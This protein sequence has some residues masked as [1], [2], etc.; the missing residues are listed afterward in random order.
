MRRAAINPL[1][2]RLEE[3][4]EPKMMKKHLLF[5]FLFVSVS[6]AAFAQT[7]STGQITGV[8]K[9]P[10]QAVVADTQVIL[11][12]VLTKVK[13][14]AITDAQGIYQ[15]S[16]LQP[17]AYVVEIDA[18]GFKPGRSSELNVTAGQTV[19]LDFALTLAGNVE[20]VYVSAG[21]VEN[22]YRVDNVK[23]GS[24]FGTV[25][26][27]NL[28]YSVNV[29]SRQLIDDTQSR[30]FKEVA[31]YLP[32]I[33]FREQQGP[34]ILRPESRGMQGTNMQNDRKD[35]M[36]FA[37]TTPSALEEYEQIEV[38]NGLGGPM[39]GPTQP[40]GVFNFVT[41]RPTDEQ[42]REVELD[43]EGE[44]VGTVHAD[45]GGRV[46]PNHMFGYRTNLVLADGTGYVDDS[47]L[48]RQLAAVALDVRITP[49]TVVEGNFSYYEL[50]QH[51]YPGWFTYA[52]TTTPLSVA[53]SKSILLPVNAPDP[54]RRGYGQSFS[55]VDMNNQIGE[56]RVKHELNRNWHLVVGVL[57]QIADRDINTAVN[58]LTDNKGDYQ[59]YLAD[60]FQNTLAPRFQVKSDLAYLTGTFKTWKI[61]HEVV[62]GS[63]GY[64]FASWQPSVPS[65]LTGTP[66]RLT[67]LCPAGSPVVKGLP[68]CAPSIATP[69]IAVLPANGIPSLTAIYIASIIHQQGFNFS[70][71]IT[72]TP[73]WLVRVGASQ[74]WIWEN[75]YSA[76]AV[77]SPGDFTSQGVS[78]TGS[79]IFKPRTN[80]TVYGTYAMSLQAPDTPAVSNATNIVINAAKALAPYHDKEGEIGYKLVLRKINFSTALFRIERPFENT[81]PAPAGACGT[82]KP[83]QTCTI[84]EIIGTQVNYGAEAVLSGRIIESLMVTGGITVLNPKLTGTPNPATDDKSL[85]GIPDYKSNILA[86]YRL[87]LLTG[88]FL[89]FDWEHVGR[90]P[91][92]DINSSYTPQYNLFDLGVRY[93]AKVFGKI[94][95]WRVTANNVSD[96]HY[97]STIN[98][99]SLIGTSAGSYLG[100]LGEPRLITASMRYDF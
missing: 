11:T 20:T 70:D 96:V 49:K 7:A 25:P 24:P 72:L 78:P 42:Y 56:V 52:P 76:A 35:G 36:G 44:S 68:V 99:G 5:I 61:G 29:I 22:A 63:T 81:A 23:P 58:K 30:N 40:S 26:I 97:W 19:N 98:P 53:G 27:V 1:K 6:L 37:V 80:M 39:Y 14:T 2:L 54:T 92:D 48:R 32:L 10:H 50:F 66:F 91:I 90:R 89:N 100:H 93:T 75:F 73:H 33:S 51:G 47:Q 65:V 83:G 46:G 8:V 55:G 57:N 64:R 16:A 79:I 95:T 3:R 67:P 62:I 94:A 43:Y 82:L 41:K 9:D 31:K 71:T 4:N 60:A 86:E 84:N 28:P 38:L 74:D 85:V 87:P 13:I 59:T 34:E 77:G 15:F 21:S 18:K 69:L 12:S 45:L 88:T 17:G